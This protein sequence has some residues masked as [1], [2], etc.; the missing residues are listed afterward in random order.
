MPAHGDASVAGLDGHREGVDGSFEFMSAREGAME[1]LMGV[2]SPAAQ[3]G[4]IEK[5]R[6]K[7]RRTCRGKCRPTPLPGAPQ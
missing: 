2:V 4:R 6:A 3:R 5:A 7:S 1:V